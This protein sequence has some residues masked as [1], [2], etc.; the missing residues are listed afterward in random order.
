MPIQPPHLA[1]R[2]CQ[3]HTLKA[4]C[5]FWQSDP[6]P[7]GWLTWSRNSPHRRPFSTISS[8][9][10]RQL[11]ERRTHPR[12]SCPAGAPEN[13]FIPRLRRAHPQP[14]PIRP[15]M[16]RSK[17]PGHGAHQ[18]PTRSTGHSR[19][20]VLCRP[21]RHRRPL[22]RV[23]AVECPRSPRRPMRPKTNLFRPPSPQGA[24]RPL[25]E[26]VHGKRPFAR[27]A[28]RHR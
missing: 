28:F 23:P 26:S 3:T 22:P 1:N 15:P 25:R 11:P 17:A 9:R 27:P 20:T 18:A 6:C 12:A 7:I 21:H 13:G 24:Q 16:K 5:W 14:R 10:R 4:R 8:R 2:L 19:A